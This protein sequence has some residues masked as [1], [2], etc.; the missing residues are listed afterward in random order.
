MILNRTTTTPFRVN[1]LVPFYELNSRLL[2]YM[3]IPCSCFP[4]NKTIKYSMS[5]K[6]KKAIFGIHKWIQ[7]FFFTFKLTVF[8]LLF[9]TLVQRLHVTKTY[10]VSLFNQNSR[11]RFLVFR[12]DTSWDTF[13]PMN[14]KTI[15]R[16]NDSRG[17]RR[18]VSLHRGRCRSYKV[19]CCLYPFQR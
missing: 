4:L 9:V 6:I 7:F 16:D 1:E 12:L 5:N 18:L 14:A 17:T 8:F 13:E 19:C 3:L 11:S 2:A 10:N 15:V